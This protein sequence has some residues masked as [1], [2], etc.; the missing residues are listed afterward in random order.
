[1]RQKLH[2]AEHGQ[3]PVLELTVAHVGIRG[4]SVVCAVEGADGLTRDLLPHHALEEAHEGDKLQPS[5]DG[6]LG[7]GGHTVSDVVELKL[8]HGAQVSSDAEVFL[9]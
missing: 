3:A 1:M 9:G 8:I 2:N 7:D 4:G 5:E 6:D